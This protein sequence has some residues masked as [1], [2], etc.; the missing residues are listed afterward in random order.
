MNEID[1]DEI[2]GFLRENSLILSLS[3]FLLLVLIFRGQIQE[4]SH[5]LF[6][7]YFIVALV[8]RL[9]SRYSIGVALALLFFTAIILVQKKEDL[10][11][12][13]A[14]YAYY[15]LVVGVVLQFLEYIRN[16]EGEPTQ[17]RRYKFKKR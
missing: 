6:L 1:I 17:R 2:R 7:A 5:Y 10:A 4:K 8:N 16:K 9:D 14:I 12:Q 13:M 11:N 15:F 3:M